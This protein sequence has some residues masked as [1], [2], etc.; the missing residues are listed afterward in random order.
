VANRL[1]RK[2][3]KSTATT[4]I[5]NHRP[6]HNSIHLALNPPS[7]HCHCLS[8]SPTKSPSHLSWADLSSPFQT[9][10]HQ[11]H[12]CKRCSTSPPSPRSSHKPALSPH[13][14]PCSTIHLA[15]PRGK[16][17]VISCSNEA[18]QKNFGWDVPSKLISSTSSSPRLATFVQPPRHQLNALFISLARIS[19]NKNQHRFAPKNDVD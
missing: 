18:R 14:N 16:T 5:S 4:F 1:Y 10:E 11:N 19:I 17:K 7:P 8:N 15:H 9:K 6:L 3:S 13:L 2:P 12:P